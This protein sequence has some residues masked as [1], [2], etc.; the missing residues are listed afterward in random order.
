M[1]R[2]LRGSNHPVVSFMLD[3][4][5][6]A[7]ADRQNGCDAKEIVL[8]SGRLDCAMAPGETCLVIELK[9]D[10]SRA[11]AKG[12]SQ[13]RGYVSELNEELK[14]PGSSTIKKLIDADSDFAKCKRFEGRIDCYKLCPTV[15]DDG[16]YSEPSAGWRKDC[17]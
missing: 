4:G 10:N 13:Y 9:P 17:S 3:Q 7:H 5:N 14:K 15:N 12:V 6:R 16:E 8:S 2:N 11:I 1:T